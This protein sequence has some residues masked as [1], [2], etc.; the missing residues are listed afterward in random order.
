MD[1]AT[2]FADPLEVGDEVLAHWDR[3]QNYPLE[4]EKDS[5]ENPLDH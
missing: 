3:T 2:Y 4:G 1:D 5:A